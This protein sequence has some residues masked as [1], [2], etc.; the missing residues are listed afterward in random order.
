MNRKYT[1]IAVTTASFLTPFMGSALN[2]AVPAIGQEFGSDVYLL[3]WVMTG[4]LLASAV[5]LLPLGRLSDILGRK[6]I[7]TGGIVFFAI[8]TFFCGWAWSLPSLIVMRIVQGMSASMIFATAIPILTLTFSPQ[9]RGMV[10][11]IN[12]GAIYTGLSLGPVVGGVINHHLGWQSIFFLT[13]GVAAL[14]LYF[15]LRHMS[16]ECPEVTDEKFDY[17]GAILY[18]IALVS[19]I[20]GSS[21]LAKWNGAIVFLLSGLVIMV[22]F[23]VYEMRQKFPLMDIALIRKNIVFA[24]SNLAALINYSATYA[25]G[26]LLSLYLQVSRGFDSQIAG[27]ILLSQ[28]ILQALFSPFAG[29]LSDRIEPR[30]VATFGMILTTVG[31]FIF[32]FLSAET[33]LWFIIFNLALQGIGFAF[34]AA[35]NNNAIMSSVAKKEYGVASAVLGTMRIVGQSFSMVLMTLITTYYLGVVS[36]SPLYAELITK[37]T[38]VSFLIFALICCGG[39]FASMAR[40]NLETKGSKESNN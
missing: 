6:K 13:A 30:Y 11:G 35:P 22:C 24:F 27:I 8:S 39:I 17:I 20:Y 7:F 18:A 31:L 16:G 3:G 15:V 29:K 10:L 4:Y 37:S 1:L 2:L 33:P 14:V 28:P 34:F 9:E 19:V 25:I 38:R 40:G 26:F 5:F 36:I 23:V 12:S 32:S 21:S